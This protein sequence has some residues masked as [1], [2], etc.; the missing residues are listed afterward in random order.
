M[1]ISSL[2]CFYNRDL[3]GCVSAP[4]IFRFVLLVNYFREFS[5]GIIPEIS[6]RVH[7]VDTSFCVSIKGISPLGCSCNSKI[8]GLRKLVADPFLWPSRS[9][10]FESF[11][12]ESFLR[13]RIAFFAS[14]F[15]F[16]LKLLLR[17]PWESFLRSPIGHRTS[18]FPW[19][20]SLRSRFP[21]IRL[22][23]LSRVSFTMGIL[24]PMMLSR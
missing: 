14:S 13:P 24:V 1:G 6:S 23:R 18:S 20:S 12:W 9:I 16:T 3:C 8:Y 15:P 19:E 17:F 21:F 5:L 4:Q 2:G 10:A 7:C 11:P 22:T